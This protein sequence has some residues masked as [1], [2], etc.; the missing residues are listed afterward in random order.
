MVS[1]LMDYEVSGTAVDIGSAFIRH[2]Q[3]CFSLISHHDPH[4]AGN[5]SQ[6]RRCGPSAVRAPQPGEVGCSRAW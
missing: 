1:P 5:R 3:G 4:H 2:R 6:R